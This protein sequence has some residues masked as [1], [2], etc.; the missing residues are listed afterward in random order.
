VRLPGAVPSGG[1]PPRLTGLCLNEASLGGNQC[2]PIRARSMR[3]CSNLIIWLHGLSTVHAG[4]VT[5]E[6][7]PPSLA[8]ANDTMLPSGMVVKVCGVQQPYL[9]GDGSF[10]ASSLERTVSPR[11]DC[12]SQ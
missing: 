9:S 2:P 6:P 10:H 7:L 11:P 4:P 8:L 12:R 1:L 3:V 5:D